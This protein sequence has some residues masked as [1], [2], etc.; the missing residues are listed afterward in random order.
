MM[1]KV[2]VGEIKCKCGIIVVVDKEEKP[3]IRAS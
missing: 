1:A 2:F 3:S